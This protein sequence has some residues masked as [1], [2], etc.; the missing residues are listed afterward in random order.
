MNCPSPM[1]IPL[2]IAPSTGAVLTSL[3]VIVI[4]SELL[5]FGVP[6]SVTVKVTST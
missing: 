5:K 6:S 1:P 4:V 2:P 3:T